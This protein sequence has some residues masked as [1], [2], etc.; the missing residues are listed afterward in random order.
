[1]KTILDITRWMFWGPVRK[2]LLLMDRKYLFIVEKILSFAA[3]TILIDRRKIIAEE[4]TKSFGNVWSTERMKK[5]VWDSFTIYVASQLHLLY[6]PILNSS[7]IDNHISVEG[8]EYVEKG[9]AKGKGVVILNPHFGPFLMI[10]PALGHRGYK[11]NQ[12]ALQGDHYRWGHRKR[13]DKKVFD[14]KFN[15]IE[16]NMP[17]KFI[18]AAAGPISIK[19]ALNALRNNEIVLYPSTG[20]GGKSW[21][22][23]RFMERTALFDLFP[24]KMALKTGASLLP[25]FVIYE[26]GALKLKIEKPIEVDT[27][28]IAESLLERYIEIL[29]SYIREYPGH[30]LMYVYEVKSKTLVGESNIFTD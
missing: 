14:I 9:F 17:V 23:V 13:I 28:P 22:T 21:H 18:N 30:F 11:I 7:N 24:F 19:E 27:N 16:G 25:A 29:D 12:M 20:R 1:M 10:M 5:A 2:I 3:Y 4:L 8:L 26:N 6:L 15:L